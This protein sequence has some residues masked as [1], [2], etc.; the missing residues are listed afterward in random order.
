MRLTRRPEPPGIAHTNARDVLMSN[1]PNWPRST[2]DSGPCDEQRS[3][4]TQPPHMRLT[5]RRDTRQRP[6]RPANRT[7]NPS[8]T[9][10]P[11]P[12]TLPLTKPPT[13]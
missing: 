1:H 6:D 8:H 3:W 4:G 10:N 12:T 5:E 2:L 7:P 9:A 13:I 11:A